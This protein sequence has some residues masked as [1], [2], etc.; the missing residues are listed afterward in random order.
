MVME[1][2]RASVTIMKALKLLTS[3][4]SNTWTRE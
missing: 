3:T 4:L 2:A 1:V